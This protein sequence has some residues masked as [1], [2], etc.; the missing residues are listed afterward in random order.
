MP[1][2]AERKLQNI[3]NSNNRKKLSGNT[4]IIGGIVLAAS[5]IILIFTSLLLLSSNSRLDAAKIFKFAAAVFSF[6]LMCCVTG[7]CFACGIN[8]KTFLQKD[9]SKPRLSVQQYETFQQQ[10]KYHANEQKQQN[11][12]EE[13]LI[14]N[15]QNKN[16]DNLTNEDIAY[17]KQDDSLNALY[18]QVQST[19]S[20]YK[21]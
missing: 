17:I 3:I 11:A 20:T 16:F 12:Y 9:S 14:E 1:N 5:S 2:V 15:I 18:N 21:Q 4:L 6:G 13:L 7:V 8:L 10:K 19:L